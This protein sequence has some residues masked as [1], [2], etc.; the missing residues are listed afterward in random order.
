MIRLN[1][2]FLEKRVNLNLIGM[3]AKKRVFFAYTLVTCIH[4]LELFSLIQLGIT[5]NIE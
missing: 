5:Y 2:A 3:R 1:G 4:W